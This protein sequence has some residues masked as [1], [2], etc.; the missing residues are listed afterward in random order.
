MKDEDVK[1]LYRTFHAPVVAFDC[2][3]KC[4]EKNGG[5]PICCDDSIAIPVLY[6]AEL[7]YLK[8]KTDLWR[9]FRGR[10]EHEREMASELPKEQRFARCKGHTAC[11]REN[12]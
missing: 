6:T 12:R 1:E 11:E 10:D 9:N 7:T 2:G 8:K 3:K 5:V 4:A